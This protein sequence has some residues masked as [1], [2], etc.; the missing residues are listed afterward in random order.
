MVSL[1]FAQ[2]LSSRLPTYST[3][4]LPPCFA[5]DTR[6]QR[7]S[8]SSDLRGSRMVRDVFFRTLNNPDTNVVSSHLWPWCELS[9]T[10]NRPRCFGPIVVYAYVRHIRYAGSRGSTPAL[11]VTTAVLFRINFLTSCKMEV[12]LRSRDINRLLAFSSVCSF[13]IFSKWE[14]RFTRCCSRTFFIGHF[15]LE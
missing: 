6:V 2:W 14:M 11:Y 1:Y 15:H 5:I 3:A 9:S 4:F 10:T 8:S 12:V 13:S 7:S